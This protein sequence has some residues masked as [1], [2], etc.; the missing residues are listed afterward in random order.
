VGW[1]TIPHL[2]RSHTLSSTMGGASPID[3]GIVTE[4]ATHQLNIIL[5]AA[6]LGSMLVPILYTLYAFTPAP[7]RRR[8]I[9]LLNVLAC[10]LGIFQ[11][12]VTV[13]IN[14]QIIAAPFLP[15]PVA[16]WLFKIATM[17]VPPVFIDTVLIFRFMAFFPAQL[18]SRRTRFGVLVFPAIVKVARLAMIGIFMGTYPTGR[19]LAPRSKAAEGLFWGRGPVIASVFG[20]QALDNACVSSMWLAATDF[21]TTLSQ[22]RVFGVFVQ[23]VHVPHERLSRKWSAR[24]TWGAFVLSRER[25]QRKVFESSPHRRP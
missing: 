21:L 15:L 11:A 3:I 23:T 14:Y 12:T 17:V 16:T 5:I 7:V 4:V 24:D 20:L 18:T 6:A 8:P 10:V 1:D 25:Y 13:G 2:P 22:L 19:L 9:F